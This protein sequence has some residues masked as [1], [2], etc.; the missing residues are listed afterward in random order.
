M[1][2]VDRG[3]ALDRADHW[4][5]IALS[6]VF[7]VSQRGKTF[8]LKVCDASGA[9]GSRAQT[10]RAQMT[11]VCS[12]YWRMQPLLDLIVVASASA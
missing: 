4:S 10:I 2:P 9:T 1:G 11:V 3:I 8:V 6:Q 5:N 7:S 12:P